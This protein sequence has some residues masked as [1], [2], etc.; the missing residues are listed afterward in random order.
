MIIIQHNNGAVIDIIKARSDV[1]LENIV[2]ADSIPTFEKREGYSG[3]LKYDAEQGLYWE[4]VAN[5]SAEAEE[6]P[7]S[8]LQTMLEEVL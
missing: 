3:L 6:I 8:E 5:P 1:S 2:V 4:Y 7:S